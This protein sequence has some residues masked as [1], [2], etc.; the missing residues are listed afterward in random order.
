MDHSQQPIHLPRVDA[1][2]VLRTDFSNPAGWAR[3]L[4]ALETPVTYGE[5]SQDVADYDWAVSYVVPVDQEQYR[6]LLPATVL[7]AAPDTG[8]DL[9]YDH[10]YL[11]D[12]ETLASERLPLL[13]IDL[14]V[15]RADAEPWPR[16]KPFRVPALQVAI[17]EIND[18]IANLFFRE[19]HDTTWSDSEVRVAR[20][21]TAL[22]EEL[23]EMHRAEGEEGG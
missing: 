1:V 19:F 10:L 22:Y 17:V 5:E 4:R 8:H 3:L 6:D 14:H 20:P 11:A 15:D 18:S 2:P 16:E 23:R 7:A 9:R 13:G 21:G 12:A